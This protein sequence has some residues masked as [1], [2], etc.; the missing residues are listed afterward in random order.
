VKSIRRMTQSEVG[1]FVQS[2]LRKCGIEVVLSGG[3]SVSIYSRGKY[4]SKDLDLVNVYSKDR[5]AI[6]GSMRELGFEETGRYFR[7]PESPFLIEFPPGPLTVGMEPVK[8]IREVKFATGLLRVISPTD[9]IKDRLAAFYHWGDNQ[10]LAQAEMV[11]LGNPIDLR[12]VARWS[13]AEGRRMEFNA[14][15]ERLTAE[16]RR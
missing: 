15:R 4:I 16:K 6:R 14:I 10:C 7:H 9:C 11:A 1:A 5:K 2:H 8:A 12:E 13:A 3:A